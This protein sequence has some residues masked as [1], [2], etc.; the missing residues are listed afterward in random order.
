M[1]QDVFEQATIWEI[2]ARALSHYS[3]LPQRVFCPVTTDRSFT[4][5]RVSPLITQ[6]KNTLAKLVLLSCAF[7]FK[8]WLIVLI[9][10][11][12]FISD[13]SLWHEYFI[14]YIREHKKRIYLS[15]TIS[16][17][18]PKTYVQRYF[19]QSCLTILKIWKDLSCKIVKLF[20]VYP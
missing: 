18:C 4:N 7:D 12:V 17:I 10:C 5:G 11:E 6:N 14:N 20:I 3:H 16:D 13:Q 2:H 15:L 1:M 19:S 8:V 9:K